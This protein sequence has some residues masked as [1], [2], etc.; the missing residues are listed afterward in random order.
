MTKAYVGASRPA[1]AFALARKL[2]IPD[3]HDLNADTTTRRLSVT[4]ITVRETSL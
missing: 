3:D 2:G 1:I 4:L